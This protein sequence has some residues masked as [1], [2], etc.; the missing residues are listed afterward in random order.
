MEKK[1]NKKNVGKGI[2]F[3]FTVFFLFLCVLAFFAVE[4]YLY[5]FGYTGFDSIWATLKGG[6]AGTG[7]GMVWRFLYQAAVPSVLMTAL[8]LFLLFYQPSRQFY[9]PGK[10]RKVVIYPLHRF[11]SV[12]FSLLISV[13]L[14]LTASVRC[15]MAEYVQLLMEETK[16]FENYYVV[17]T[18]G[19]VIFPKEKR[20]LIC[21]YLESMEISFLSEELG[22]GND[23]NVIPELYE[24]ARDNLNFSHNDS[25]GGFYSLPG[26]QWTIGALVSQTAGI[27]LKVPFGMDKNGYGEDGFLPELRSMSNI[28]HDAG[29]YQAF[30]LGSDSNFGGQRPFFLEHGT[31]IVYDWATAQQDEIIPPGYEVWWGMEDERLFSYAKKELPKIAALEQPFAFTMITIDTHSIDGYVCDLCESTYEEQYEN[32]LACSSR[33]VLEFVQWLQQQDFYENTTVVICGDHPTMDGAYIR[34][35][36]V[37]DY[38]RTVYNCFLNTPVTAENPKNREFTA[39]DMFPTFLASIGCTIPGDRLGLGTNLFSGEPTLCEQLGR[40]YLSQELQKYSRYYEKNFY[41][42]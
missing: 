41:G 22:G 15:G 32:V 7:G 21:I 8:L 1:G 18:E 29:Y 4:W 12:L 19:N 9:F 30:M 26:S 24:L 23:Q 31:D 38:E 34:S 35:N 20:N 28:L 39:F 37:E 17:P 3:S 6:M 25:V 36:I 5:S 10:K 40:Q 11:F 42:E 13:A 27:P 33:Q 14:F 2:L 16:L